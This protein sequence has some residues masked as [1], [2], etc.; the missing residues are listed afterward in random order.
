MALP[1]PGTSPVGAFEAAA[2]AECGGEPL[3]R[4]VAAAEAKPADA[5]EDASLNEWLTL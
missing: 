3:R 2:V 4:A 1:A 5:G